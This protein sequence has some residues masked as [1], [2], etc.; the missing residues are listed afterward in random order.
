MFHQRVPEEEQEEGGDVGDNDRQAETRTGSMSTLAA[1]AS[2]RHP[3][4]VAV[5]LLS[6]RATLNTLGYHYGR[7][8]KSTRYV[9][10]RRMCV[11]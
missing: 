1:S 6:A 9:H 11:L 2:A 8:T 5:V 4:V 10:G 7:R 3:S